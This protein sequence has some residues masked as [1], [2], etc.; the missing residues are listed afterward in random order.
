MEPS[1]TLM[2]ASVLVVAV[3]L[4]A[5]AFFTGARFGAVLRGLGA[6]SFFTILIL[7]TA[8]H[9]CHGQYAAM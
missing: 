6:V 9:T 7:F 4:V 3:V 8:Q 5:S 1:R 2:V